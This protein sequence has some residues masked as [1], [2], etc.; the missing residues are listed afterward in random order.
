M[1]QHFSVFEDE[2]RFGVITQEGFQLLLIILGGVGLEK[3]WANDVM[4]HVYLMQ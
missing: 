3:V 4:H 1:A 2:Y